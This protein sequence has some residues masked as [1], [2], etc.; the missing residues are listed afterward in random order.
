[1]RHLAIV[2][3]LAG[4]AAAAPPVQD[5]YEGKS[6]AELIEWCRR[7]ITEREPGMGTTMSFEDFADKARKQFEARLPRVLRTWKQEGSAPSPVEQV[8]G[9][10]RVYR[11]WGNTAQAAKQFDAALR[12]APNDW[13]KRLCHVELAQLYQLMD[14]ESRARQYLAQAAKLVKQAS[15]QQDT[16]RLVAI[17]KGMRE[18]RDLLGRRRDSPKDWRV[19]WELCQ[20]LMG[21]RDQHGMPYLVVETLVA[22][23]W[24]RVAFPSC[25]A[26]K[27]GGVNGFM[28]D[29]A[30]DARDVDS[31]LEAADR[32]WQKG[33]ANAR[34]ASGE[35]VLR[36][37]T[38]LREDEDMRQH[39]WR[40]FRWLQNEKPNHP[41]VAGGQADKTLQ[42]LEKLKGVRRENTPPPSPPWQR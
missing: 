4:F 28:V 19:Q 10:G 25:P 35:L 8:I 2:A 30:A 18:Y 16:D 3:A 24:L 15:L 21:F 20:H 34:V 40:C 5:P 9:L 6:A 14:N 13:L 41:V 17:A 33:E 27:D 31:A 23:D 29:V 22:L 1:M 39:A 42:E 32:L 12:K 36:V 26:S 7:R 38:L 11:S 37:G